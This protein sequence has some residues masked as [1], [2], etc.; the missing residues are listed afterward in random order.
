[1]VNKEKTLSKVPAS[2]V[3]YVLCFSAFLLLFVSQP[4]KLICLS[5]FVAT[6]LLYAFI[7]FHKFFYASMLSLAFIRLHMLLYACICFHM[8]SF[9]FKHFHTHS[10]AFICF[11]MLSYML[12]YAL[13]CFY[14]LFQC[15]I[16][17][18]MHWK[19]KCHNKKL[20]APL[21]TGFSYGSR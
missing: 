8:P 10:Y 7:C 13:V 6:T 2:F 9:A 11:Q 16:S 15:F 14:M 17:F 21:F 18:Y 4:S 20:A 5:Q 3:I 12:P 19:Q 1:M